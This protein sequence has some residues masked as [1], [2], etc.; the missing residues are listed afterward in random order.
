MFDTNT[1]EPEKEAKAGFDAQSWVNSFEALTVEDPADLSETNPAIPH[2]EIVRITS[3]LDDAADE[4]D[5]LLSRGFFRVLCLF[6]DLHQWRG[7][8]AQTVSLKV[9]D[10][11]HVR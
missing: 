7:L 5:K 10:L 8:I 1:A 9:V 11:L 6:H 4:D 3:T 2:S